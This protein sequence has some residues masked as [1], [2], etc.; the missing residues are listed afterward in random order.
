MAVNFENL[1]SDDREWL[2]DI[3]DNLKEILPLPFTDSSF[4]DLARKRNIVIPKDSDEI[5]RDGPSNYYHLNPYDDD[6]FC[7]SEFYLLSKSDFQILITYN[8]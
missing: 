8:N 4:H 6:D 3:C 1:F 7:K 2:Q 5:L